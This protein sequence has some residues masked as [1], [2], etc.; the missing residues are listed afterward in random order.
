LRRV[1]STLQPPLD[2]LDCAP[3]IGYS[4]TLDFLKTGLAGERITVSF[5]PGHRFPRVLLPQT[6]L[7]RVDLA[8][9]LVRRRQM[10]NCCHRISSS[11]SRNTAS[12]TT[13]G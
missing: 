1:A 8:S 10:A 2:L 9:E 5:V 13:R 3:V 12:P 7:G 6:V 11:N 4:I